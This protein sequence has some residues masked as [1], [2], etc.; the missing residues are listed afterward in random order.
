MTHPQ[1]F[2]DGLHAAPE[3]VHVEL[4]KARTRDGHVEIDA[5]VQ[6]VDLNGRLQVS[7]DGKYKGQL[8]ADC[9][10]SPVSCRV[11][12][13]ICRSSASSGRSGPQKDASML[14]L[15]ERCCISLL[16]H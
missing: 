12:K 6:G 8:M 2:L 4:L 7:D 13:C 15:T 11:A 9:W 10:V 16:Q 1:D 14:N 3:Q 5:L